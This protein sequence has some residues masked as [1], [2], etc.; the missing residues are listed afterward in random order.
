[1]ALTPE[2]LQELQDLKALLAE[3]G[4]EYIPT[5]GEFQA[6]E[7]GSEAYKGYKQGELKSLAEGLQYGLP[8]AAGIASGGLSV[9]AQMGIGFVSSLLG[10][11][12]ARKLE[13]KP[14][15]TEEGIRELGAAGVE[16]MVPGFKGRY[17]PFKYAGAAGAAGL[18]SAAI[19][20]ELSKESP[21]RDTL[22]KGGVP[23]IVGG[24][25]G[26]VQSALRGGVK[27]AEQAA[28]AAEEIEAIGPG[29]RATFGQALPRYSGLEARVS[30][31]VGRE[32]LTKAFERQNEA[33]ANSVESLAALPRGESR[34]IVANALQAMGVRERTELLS[35]AQAVANAQDALSLVE[36]GARKQ[37]VEDTLSKAEKDLEDAVTTGFMG[38]Y[39]MKAGRPEYSEVF[40]KIESGK[41]IES[42]TLQAKK[43]FSD[44]ADVLYSDPNIDTAKVGFNILA[45]VGRTGTSVADEV[46][47][48]FSDSPITAGGAI[49]P[50]FQPYFKKLMAVLDSRSPTTLG[51][52]RSI[53]E[54]L[55]NAAESQGQA[56]GTKAQ[57]SLKAIASKITETLDDQAASVL[58][59]AGANALST[60]N[61]FYSE[62]RPKFENYGVESAFLVRGA[63][64]G[65]TAG[66]MAGEVAQEGLEAPA[67]TNLVDLF[68]GLKRAGVA[69]VPDTGPVRE[70]LR[71]GLLDQVISR[72]GKSVTVDYQKLAELAGQVESQSPGALQK[73]GLGSMDDLDTLIKFKAFRDAEPGVDTIIQAINSRTPIGNAIG[74]RA[75]QD[76]TDVAD[77]KSVVNALE[78]KAIGTV[79]GAAGSKEAAEALIQAKA[80]AINDLL[81]EATRL[82]K[83]PRLQSLA[84]FLEPDKIARYKEIIGTPM[85]NRIENQILP[86]FRRIEQAR[87]AA[88]QA[89]ATVTGAAEERLISGAV[90]APLQAM[91]RG[92]VASL[93]NLLGDWISAVKYDTLSKVLAR[94]GGATGF[95]NAATQLDMLQKATQG[96]PIGQ[97]ARILTDYAEGKVPK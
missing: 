77:V 20:D 82:G 19:R 60:A 48:A 21:I 53:R 76:L 18:T 58:S 14:I 56:F 55:Y 96:Q 45:P 11:A 36:G 78:R 68:E 23:A 8:L 25:G 26:A 72:P 27:R 12:G 87:S 24:I 30:S 79:G 46:V 86:G 41:Q 64:P 97:V 73:L 15:A 88:R 47:K 67:Y 35:K 2:E 31:Q 91:T 83:G 52:L 70:S 57:R 43:A 5:G 65:T 84:D 66:R 33:I 39:T 17:L 3:N 38:R 7:Y 34:D 50:E 75:L 63:K 59:P 71:Q 93:S 81:I 94:A 49:I 29:V 6:P 9:P 85:M 28:Q 16:G 95:R 44:Q 51:E 69:G 61:K 37:V 62:F 89:G 1:M 13:D 80:N 22:V 32:S 54:D 40:K 42:A 74:V 10:K 90:Q 92:P 4:D